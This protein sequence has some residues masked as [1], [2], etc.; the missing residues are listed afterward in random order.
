MQTSQ[1]RVT[2]ADGNAYD[3][4][5]LCLD[6]SVAGPYVLITAAMHGTELQGSEALCR[7]LPHI[8]D[9]LQTGRCL[10]VPFANPIAIRKHQP[11]VDFEIQ[12]KYSRDKQ[13]NLNCAWP[14]KEK[15]TS[16][17]RLSFAM[18]HSIV[19]EASHL[20][21]L[22]CWNHVMASAALVRTGEPESERLAECTGL[23]FGRHIKGCLEPPHG[24]AD[25]FS[26]SNRPAV[27]IEFSGQYGFREATL[28]SAEQAILGYLEGLGM[29][30]GIA[31]GKHARMIWLDKA[32]TVVVKAPH[33]GIFLPSAVCLAQFVRRNEP[34]GTIR[35]I[36]TFEATEL[37]APVDGW[38]NRLG[39]M[40]PDE[41]E[42]SRMFNHPFV[43]AGQ[44]VAE[45]V[46]P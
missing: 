8:A 30:N 12:K 33:D 44:Q 22:H 17:E 14:G 10:A 7:V 45:M 23:Q 38:L 34:L 31:H 13:H 43:K 29:L 16:A 37:S 15:G 41:W 2:L 24:L 5:Y 46:V 3:L 6:S 28:H 25:L 35:D 36:E 39:P 4:P 27:T 11:H 18:A 42:T 20:L 9:R 26:A 19:P 32:Q 21:D 40:Q 1:I